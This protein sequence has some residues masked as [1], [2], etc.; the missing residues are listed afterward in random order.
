MHRTTDYR[1]FPLCMADAEEGENTQE[2]D[3]EKS[4]KQH[5]D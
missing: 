3:K 1:A 5:H 4:D 2:R